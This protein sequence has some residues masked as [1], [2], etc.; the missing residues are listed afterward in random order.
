MFSS[1]IIF[2][3][4][5]SLGITIG[6]SFLQKYCIQI[7]QQLKGKKSIIHTLYSIFKLLKEISLIF[8]I[9]V[10][11]TFNITYK[12]CYFTSSFQFI[13][14]HLLLPPNEVFFMDKYKFLAIL[15]TITLMFTI[16]VP[17]FACSGGGLSKTQMRDK[18][19]KENTKNLGSEMSDILD[20]CKDFQA[21]EL[22]EDLKNQALVDEMLKE[23]QEEWYKG[24]PNITQLVPETIDCSDG[25]IRS[26]E[27][28]G[29]II[30]HYLW[31]MYPAIKKASETSKNFYSSIW[32]GTKNYFNSKTYPELIKDATDT[33]QLGLI[34]FTAFTGGTSAPVTIGAMVLVSEVG[35]FVENV[36]ATPTG[37]AINTYT[38]T[39]DMGKAALKGTKE[40]M[41]G[42]STEAI[43]GGIPEVVKFKGVNKIGREVGEATLDK[44][45]VVFENSKF[46]K[47]FE[48][49]VD[50]SINNTA[51][52]IGKE[53]YGA[54]AKK[55]IAD[56]VKGKVVTDAAKNQAKKAI[57]KPISYWEGL[58][59]DF[60][61]SKRSITTQ[62]NTF[63]NSLEK[64]PSKPASYNTK[65][66][67]QPGSYHY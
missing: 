54:N 20:Q 48:A 7:L 25:C 50:K 29:T 17:V 3:A 33:L 27:V 12:K 46:K 23:M 26:G 28:N 15:I 40:A 21:E 34:G 11:K 43:T 58:K 60:A 52:A 8:L 56:V 61:Y 1:F 57:N 42:L 67:T 45:S 16:T 36:F 38:E 14:Y 35:G 4:G 39:G 37:E 6:I 19:E 24:E 53:L 5:S 2:E 66:A 62:F 22:A 59:R 41:I 30:D 49:A 47:S 44:M 51:E 63:V 31:T 13:C 32:E 65:P 64:T 18:E 10:V 9:L 55:I